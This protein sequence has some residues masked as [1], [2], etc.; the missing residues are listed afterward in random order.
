MNFREYLNEAK[1]P[2]KSVKFSGYKKG[3]ILA[4]NQKSTFKEMRG[5][6]MKD[7]KGKEDINLKLKNGD[8][9]TISYDL[10]KGVVNSW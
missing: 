2:R 6:I 3:N 9:I 1:P 5:E 4:F 8:V 7:T 10:A